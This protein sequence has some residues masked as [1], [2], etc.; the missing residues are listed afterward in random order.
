M[1]QAQAPQAAAT[2]P[3]KANPVSPA[4]VYAGFGAR[5]LASLVDG[6]I[7]GTIYLVLMIPVFILGIVTASSGGNRDAT[8]IVSILIFLLQ[9]IGSFIALGY[10]IYFTAKGQ[11]LGKKALKIRVVRVE[12]GESPGYTKAFLREVIGKMVS[13]MVFGLGYLWMLWDPKK[14]TW[15]DKIADTVV[16]KV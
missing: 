9:V 3:V 15:H 7:V 2:P 12:S 5:F 16:V 14:Q 10:Y 8:A 13:A 1:E 6:I 11:T 4:A